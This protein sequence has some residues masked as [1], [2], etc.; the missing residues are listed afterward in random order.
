[1]Q[2]SHQQHFNQAS[3]PYRGEQRHLAMHLKEF[4]HHPT[5]GFPQQQQFAKGPT[6]DS[7][8]ANN[9]EE[10]SLEVQAVSASEPK[11]YAPAFYHAA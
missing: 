10:N 8:N 7:V 5:S 9:N 2:A 3:Y 11:F 1:M 6:I 4:A